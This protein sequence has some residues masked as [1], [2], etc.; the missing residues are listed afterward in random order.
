MF[1]FAERSGEAVRSSIRAVHGSGHGDEA[2][3]ADRFHP[4][5]S[6][7]TIHLHFKGKSD[8]RN[9][10]FSRDI[11]MR[12]CLSDVARFGQPGDIQLEKVPFLL[13]E[14]Q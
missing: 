14:T 5:R 1:F 7:A 10:N 2:V 13:P 11:E 8:T 12:F 3:L 6:T 4:V 9:F